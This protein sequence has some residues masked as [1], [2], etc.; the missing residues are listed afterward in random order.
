MTASFQL[1]LKNCKKHLQ[2]IMKDVL[3][4]KIGENNKSPSPATDVFLRPPRGSLRSIFFRSNFIKVSPTLQRAGASRESEME[5]QTD[6]R[7]R[8]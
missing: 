5:R 3:M 6:K 1:F 8:G 2:R 4:T 7:K